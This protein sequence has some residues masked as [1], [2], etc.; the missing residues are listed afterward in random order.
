MGGDTI[1]FTPNSGTALFRVPAAGG[2]P[3]ALTTLDQGAGETSHRFPMFLPGGRRFVYTIRNT[4][5]T[6]SALYAGDLDSN[7][8]QRLFAAES[9]AVY[10]PPGYL[11]F[12]R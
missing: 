12:V 1:V 4:D 10:S 3:T 6:K 9:N 8:K 2:A 7:L 5:P 11:L